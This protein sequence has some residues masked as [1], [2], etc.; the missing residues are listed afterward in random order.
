MHIDV[1][2]GGKG[3]VYRSSWLAGNV[4]LAVDVLAGIVN[5]Q[6]QTKQRQ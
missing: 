1:Q 3:G 5:E 4:N 6:K 2:R